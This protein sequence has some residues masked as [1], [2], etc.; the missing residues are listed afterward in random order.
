MI[1]CLIEKGILDNYPQL[2]RF[3]SK[4]DTFCNVIHCIKLAVLSDRIMSHN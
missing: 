2:H 4:K 3:K 1:I